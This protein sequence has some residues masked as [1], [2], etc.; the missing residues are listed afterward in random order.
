MNQYRVWLTILGSVVKPHYD[1]YVDVWAESF[2]DAGLA[3]VEKLT[4]GVH[5]D[6]RRT[7]F[8]VDRVELLQVRI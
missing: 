4:Q 2:C 7:D 1:G 6:R 3:A 8:R 5:N